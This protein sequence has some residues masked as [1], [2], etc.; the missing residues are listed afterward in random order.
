MQ[1][2][3]GEDREPRFR[4]ADAA[5]SL[6]GIE[7]EEIRVQVE[8][9]IVFCAVGIITVRHRNRYG[10]SRE[11]L[12]RKPIAD[13]LD[14]GICCAIHIGDG[15]DRRGSVAVD[16]S[17][18]HAKLRELSRRQWNRDAADYIRRI[19]WTNGERN[20]GEADRWS[21]Q[22]VRRISGAATIEAAVRIE[23]LTV[24]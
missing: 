4:Q 11:A 22:L 6:S 16:G 9:P 12:G 24:G 21:S 7:R 17:R 18:Q 2:S 10:L 13:A 15:K 19:R 3:H 20:P 23:H 8:R 5:D 14:Y 1:H